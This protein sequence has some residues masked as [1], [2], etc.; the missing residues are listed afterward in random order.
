MK[1]LIILSVAMLIGCLRVLSARDN[2]P[3]LSNL[4]ATKNSPIYTTYAAAME[5]S[6]FTLDEGY[7][8][9]FYDSSCGIDFTTDTGGDLC[10]AFKKGA[11]Y[12]YESQ[13]LYRQPVITVS[14]PDMVKYHYAPYEKLQVDATF[15]VYSSHVAV[16]DIVLKNTGKQKLDFQVIPF[17]RNDYRT[18]N[19]VQFYAD[20]NAVTFDHEELPDGWTLE[21]KVPYVTPVNDVLLLSREADRM[22]SYRSYKWKNVEIPHEINIK[23]KPVYV[24]WGRMSHQDGGRCRHWNPKPQIM[25]MLNN[26]PSKIITA[27]A[28]R[29]GSTDPN[30]NRYGY[31]GIELGNFSKINNGDV[32]TVSILCRETGE[33]STFTDT[34]KNIADEHL[35][36]K[37]I[38]FGENS[39]LATP[40]DI[41]KDIWGSGTELR[42]FWKHKSEDMTFNIYRRDYRKNGYYELIE[43]EINQNFFTD[44]NIQG[45]KIYG[46][47]VVAFDKNGK[48]SMHTEEVNNI[49]G[50]DFLTDIRYPD[51]LKNDIKDLSRVVAMPVKIQL[52]PGSS[53]HLR[54]VRA[55]ARAN[56]S[57]QELIKRA[58]DVIGEDLDKYLIANEKLYSKIPKFT[59]ENSDHEML[60][61]NAFNLMRQV[62][63]PPENKSNYNYY[64]FSREPQWGWGH[65][66]QVFHESITM[67]AYAHMDPMSAMNSQRVYSERQYESGYINYR[68]GPYLDEIIEHNDELTS[69]APWYAWQNWEVYKITG[70]KNFLMEMYESS[71]KFYNY[72][73]ANRD[74]DDDGLCEWGAHAVLESVRDAS[75]A[76]WDEVGWPTNFEGLDVNCMLVKEAKSLAAMAK[77]LGYEKESEYW[78]KNALTRQKLI[79]E[80]MWDEETGFYYNV[81]KM[82]NDFTF[83]NTNDLKREEIIGFLP[84]WA[85]IANKEQAERLVEKL[86]DSKKFWRKYGVPSLAADDSYYNPKG[87]WNGPVW[88][89][90]DFLVVDGLLQYGYDEE[91]KEIVLRVATNMAEQLKK[92][93]QFWEFYSPDDQWAGYHRQYIW[94]GIINR[95]LID[96]LDLKVE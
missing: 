28:P 45:D 84:L 57:E 18:F 54:I 26:D 73:T 88:V 71:K 38:I 21:H 61:W 58:K 27:T 23:K 76:V 43:K 14:Y 16:H 59:F 93:H 35:V 92:D 6:E 63:L 56:V 90:W 24:I 25:V 7:H 34:V 66:G 5:R 69:S 67:L 83:K 32:Y 2:I 94:A 55:V 78:K 44:K 75:V 80:I 74:K 33:Y 30:I 87:Y 62:M 15:L 50:S 31:Y 77:E 85:G 29:W 82:D 86:T 42:L 10:L 91:A 51:Q 37:D 65:G 12:V 48:M 53:E 60:Y 47:L 17:I 40:T 22:T 9:L 70:D 1:K 52:K 36:R 49:A 89:E 8:F 95:M 68:T 4:F 39:L 79:N 46:Y 64:V 11:D 41:D 13:N 20:D 72:Y 3:Y 19:N 96:V 81:D